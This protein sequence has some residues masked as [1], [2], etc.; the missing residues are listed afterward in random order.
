MEDIISKYGIK[1]KN[2]NIK[3]T[4]TITISTVL[5]FNKYVKKIL[6]HLAVRIDIVRISN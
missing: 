5:Q 3:S 6:P 4:D 1:L 2:A